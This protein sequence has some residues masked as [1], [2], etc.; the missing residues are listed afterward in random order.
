[1]IKASASSLPK[2]FIYL[3]FG[4]SLAPFALQL[5][6]MDFG[7]LSLDVGPSKSSQL[8]DRQ[9]QYLVFDYFSGPFTHFILEWTGVAIAISTGILAFIQYRITG[10]HVT[11]II[12][13]A[14]FCAGC[15]DAF[16]VL[17]AT[18]FIQ[19][20][21]DIENFIP[22]TWTI[23]RSFN[24]LI[25]LVGTSVFLTNTDKDLPSK[26]RSKFVILISLSFFVVSFLLVQVS[27]NFALPQM[28]FADQFISRPYDLF[29]LMLYLIV[30][31]YVFPKFDKSEKSVF[32]NA[33]MWSMVPAVATQLHIAI[34]SNVL[35]DDDFNVAHVLKAVSYFVP[36]VGMAVDYVYN[37]YEV[38]KRRVGQLEKAYQSLERKNKE[39]EQFAYIASHDLQEPLHTV[40]S[41]VDLMNHEY[42]GK[43][44]ANADQYL[45]FISEAS[46]RMGNLIKGLLDYSR[47]GTGK[48][49]SVVDCS[50]LVDNIQKDLQKRISETETTLE[51]G[52]LPVIKGYET[53]LRL[54]FQNLVSNAIK[55]KKKTEPT[56][57]K[58]FAVPGQAQ[59]QFYVQ[60][61]GIGISEKYHERIF[62]IFKR[63][64]TRNEYAGTGIG[65]AHCRKLVE[66]HNGRIWVESKEGE[67]S[68]FC[69]T[70]PK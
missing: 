2:Y 39:L 25:L 13:M 48:K 68:T 58:I 23:S 63:L 49:L 64:H 11:S 38:E 3:I 16:H 26:K 50:L 60:D 27:A 69:F 31:L 62:D 44:D 17:T 33:L 15:M 8:S 28:T 42:K 29:P 9:F 46:M 5:M 18:K 12:G 4:V 22:F 43:L 6:G 57:V 10:N 19:S 52:S 34:G 59:W 47:I 20:V 40:R 53:E 32:S 14:L 37:Y 54:L 66:L 7:S 51:V 70:I 41:V 1:M 61:T 21:V 45:T 24:A 36:F 30:G 67:G 56:H 55:F 65:L 35:F